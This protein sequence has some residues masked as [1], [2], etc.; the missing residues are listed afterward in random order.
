MGNRQRQR[1]E[2]RQKTIKTI[3]RKRESGK[4]KDRYI[5]T[6]RGVRCMRIVSR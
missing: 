6:S 2:R 1:K 5:G 3:K 4:K